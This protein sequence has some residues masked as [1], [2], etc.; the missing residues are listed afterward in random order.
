MDVKQCIICSK[1]YSSY[2][3][4]WNHNKKFH[5][6]L[7]QK[8]SISPQ[9]SSISP[10]KSSILQNPLSNMNQCK[11][12]TKTYTRNDNLIRHEKVCKKNNK[13][14]IIEENILL[15]NELSNM[16]NTIE[17]LKKQM[18]QIINKQYKM[19]PKT[20]QKINKQLNFNNSNNTI[21]S[22][23]TVNFYLYRKLCFA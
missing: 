19:H 12:C 16:I 18:K 8:S 21:C 5:N 7:T 11:Y 3:S 17:D 9:N 14:E 22:N 20:L 4:L 2:K 13:D 23:N 15:K 6:S 1:E 10:Q